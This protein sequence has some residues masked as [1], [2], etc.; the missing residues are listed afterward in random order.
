M[1]K[2]IFIAYAPKSAPPERL[3]YWQRVLNDRLSEDYYPLV[4]SGKEESVSF[5]MFNGENL[6]DITLEELRKEITNK[7]QPANEKAEN[8]KA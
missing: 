6:D 7:M 3:E 4:V 8:P 2:P 1:A 5:E